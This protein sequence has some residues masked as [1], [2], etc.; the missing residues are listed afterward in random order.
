[1][2]LWALGAPSIQVAEPRIV[3]RIEDLY[4]RGEIVTDVLFDYEVDA[5]LP[6]LQQF[7]FRV[8]QDRGQK[9]VEGQLR[10]LSRNGWF[11]L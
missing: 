1:M 6:Q 2:A 3:G 9:R 7:G 5:P 11:Q 4:D 10:R 8:S